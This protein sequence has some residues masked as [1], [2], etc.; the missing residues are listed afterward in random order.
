ML[1]K[2]TAQSFTMS[3]HQPQDLGCRALFK[4]WERSELQCVLKSLCLQ[5]YYGP[6][7][8]HGLCF[9]PRGARVQ[10]RTLHTWA[11]S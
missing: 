7:C 2:E 4:L 9:L 3:L 1:M 11:Q 10:W 6:F 5:M 8:I